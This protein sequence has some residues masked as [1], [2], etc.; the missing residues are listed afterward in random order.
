MT[1]TLTITKPTILK[2]RPLQ[3]Q[4]L[5]NDEKLPFGKGTTFELNTCDRDRNHWR[6]TFPESTNRPGIFFVY[7]GHCE[8]ENN[9]PIHVIQAQGDLPDSV[10]LK[11]P[12]KYQLDNAENP[13]GSCNVTS[14]A[15]CLEFLDSDLGDRKY[16]SGDGQ[17]EDH[18]YRFMENHDLDRHSPQD[19]EKLINHHY[20]PIKDSFTPWGTIERCKSHL[21]SGN[22]CVIHGYFTSFGHIIVLV[23]YDNKGFLVH[24]PYG[25][26]F[27]SGYDTDASGAYLH[28]SFD[29]I[30]R[31]CIPDGQFWVHYISK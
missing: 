27:E 31:T 18:L 8:V 6:V 28:Y 22:P 29:L 16:K 26:W 19:L 13:L 12:Y 7:E 23:G 11:V 20:Y 25:E 30:K 14:V 17:L 5:R 4:E 21:A 24:D 9:R 1:I 15:M 10:K 2:S 3:S